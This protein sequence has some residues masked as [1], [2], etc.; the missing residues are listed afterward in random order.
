MAQFLEKELT[1]RMRSSSATM[2]KKE[3]ARGPA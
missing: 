2:S 1:K 3:G